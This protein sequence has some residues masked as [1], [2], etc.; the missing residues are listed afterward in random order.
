[1]FFLAIGLVFAGLYA[2]T[3]EIFVEYS[4]YCD[5]NQICEVPFYV[6]S[7][8][9]GHLFIYYHLTSFNQNYESYFNSFNDYQLTGSVSNPLLKP[10][11]CH[12]AETNAELGYIKAIDNITVLNASAPAIPCGFL[13]YSYFNGEFNHFQI[14]LQ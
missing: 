11:Y 3:S 14:L 2:Q 7:D 4:D 8:M 6:P 13:A 12:G 10:D 5:V 9:P 1:M